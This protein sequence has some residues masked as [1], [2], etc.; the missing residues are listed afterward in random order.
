MLYLVFVAVASVG[1]A[2]C[3]LEEEISSGV[4]LSFV[5][6]LVEANVWIKSD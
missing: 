6:D 5:V 3:G 2:E 4:A 1:T